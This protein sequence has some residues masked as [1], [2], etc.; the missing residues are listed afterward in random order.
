VSFIPV[1]KGY[2]K[3]NPPLVEKMIHALE[4][5]DGLRVQIENLKMGRGQHSKYLP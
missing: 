2:E 3:I 5:Y 1:R 4:E